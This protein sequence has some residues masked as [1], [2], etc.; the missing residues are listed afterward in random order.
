MLRFS[1][2]LL[3]A[4]VTLSS[5]VFARQPPPGP[6]TVIPS[7]HPRVNT[8]RFFNRAANVSHGHAPGSGRRRFSNKS[9]GLMPIVRSRPTVNLATTYKPFVPSEQ[10]RFDCDE[11]RVHR[12]RTANRAGTSPEMSS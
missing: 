6:P 9:F 12:T 10:S 11:G 2:A 8:D 1:A 5:P 4:A 3:I 7:S